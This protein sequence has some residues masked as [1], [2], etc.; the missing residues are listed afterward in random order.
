M[1]KKNL[2]LMSLEDEKI[3]KIANV[4]SNESSKKILD[5]LSGKEYA[6]ESEIAKELG[7]AIS[8]V[9]YNMQQ[10]IDAGLVSADEYHYSEKGREVNRYKLANKYI[11]IAPKGTKKQGLKQ[12]LKNIL[13]VGI[14]AL[15][16]AG[17]IEIATRFWQKSQMMAS[18]FAGAGDDMAA[19]TFGTANDEAIQAA[20]E[21]VEE[22]A[23]RKAIETPADSAPS[24]MEAA[25]E[26]FEATPELI[27]Q[28][29]QQ[30]PLWENIALWFL[31][32]AIFTIIVFFI[33]SYYKK[34][35][36]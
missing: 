16:T 27:S 22:E 34:R 29:V 24:L 10:L 20:A 19:G 31:I 28:T 9:H 12:K 6:T 2:I 14:L 11:I 32:G 25:P 18:T 13:P 30:T 5:Y 26:A 15:A 3:N 36:E 1:A 23:M 33:L 7:I 21:V 8:T 4:V 17:V 35:E